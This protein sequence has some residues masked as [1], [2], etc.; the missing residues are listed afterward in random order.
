MNWSKA[1]LPPLGEGTTR[2][3]AASSQR[4]GTVA[5]PHRLR[6]VQG[7][8]SVEQQAGSALYGRGFTLFADPVAKCR[9][10]EYQASC[11]YNEGVSKHSL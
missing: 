7:V 8:V 11:S 3:L 5:S 6:V 9:C 10:E 1:Y 2:P 4:A